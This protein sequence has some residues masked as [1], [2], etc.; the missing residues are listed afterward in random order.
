MSLLTLLLSPLLRQQ[1]MQHP[2]ISFPVPVLS[3]WEGTVT[4]FFLRNI[5][6][7]N[8][9]TLNKKV[10]C[11]PTPKL[12]YNPYKCNLHIWTIQNDHFFVMLAWQ[13]RASSQ[14][15]TSAIRIYILYHNSPGNDSIMT[16]KTLLITILDHIF[17]VCYKK[18]LIHFSVFQE[19]RLW[20]IGV[21][22]YNTLLKV[23][24]LVQIL[25]CSVLITSIIMFILWMD[26]SWNLWGNKK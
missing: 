9:L 3:H 20:Q 15:I 13:K 4:S 26:I 10:I 16:Q 7:Y 24:W 19:D 11:S 14:G 12:S 25:I 18:S 5:W 1:A 22:L 2:Y 17:Y 8:R 21:P 6:I 23:D